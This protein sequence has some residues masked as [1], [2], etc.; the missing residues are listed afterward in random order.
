MASAYDA[1][2]DGIYY[3]L[4]TKA[5]QAEVTSGDTKYSGSV[6]IPTTV[7]YNGVAFSVTSIGTWAFSG[8]SGL[9]SV[10]IPSSVTTIEGSAFFGCSGL[11]SVTIPS[12]VTSIGIQS[13]YGCFGLTSVTIPSSVTS[14]GSG[15]FSGTAWLNNQSDGVVYAGNVAYTYKGSMPVGSAI[16]LR[17]E[18]VGIADRAFSN[19]I[20]M[21]SIDIPNSVT[22]IGS[23][24]FQDCTG[25]TSITIPNSVT[26]ISN[27]A[28]SGCTGLTSITIPNSV[29]SIGSSAFSN[30]I[31]L[32]TFT[33]PNSVTSIG[34][35]AFSGCTGLTSIT[36]PNSVTSIGGSAFDGCTGITSVAL[37]CKEIGSWFNS[38]KSIK[39]VVLGDEV[40]TIGYRAFDG[41]TGLTSITIPNS[42]TSVGDKAFSGCT[43]L[44]SITLNCIEID[45]WFR[46]AFYGCTGITSV[47]L[48]CKEIGSCF[49]SNKSIKE[50][51]LGDEVTTIGYR[52]FDGCTDLTSITI[53]NS[54]TSIG[55]SAFSSCT[56]LTSV[57]IPQSVVSVGKA[58]FKNCSN[59]TTVTLNSNIETL[60]EEAF[61]ECKMLE[62]IYIDKLDF[63]EKYS[64][65]SAPAKK[66]FINGE[67]L[68]DIVI[69][70]GV[71][72]IENYN[73]IA[74]IKTVTIPSSITSIKAGYGTK[75]EDCIYCY[76]TTPPET[77]SDSYPY[78]QNCFYAPV[79]Y[80]PY[81]TKSEYNT[82][83]HWGNT[84]LFS[85]IVEMDG[86]VEE[87]IIT[88]KEAGTLKEKLSEL[89]VT[90]I[91]HLTLRGP[92]DANDL[93]LIRARDGRLSTLDVLD[94]KDVILVPKDRVFYNSWKRAVDMTFTGYLNCI[95]IGENG[96]TEIVTGE[97]VPSQGGG[98]L[99][100]N[101]YDDLAYAFEGMPLKRV[102]WPKS[103]KKIGE[104]SF[105]NSGLEVLEMSENP[106]MIGKKAFNNCAELR[107]LPSLSGVTYL[108]SEAFGGCKQLLALDNKREINLTSLDSIPSYAFS[109]CTSIKSFVLSFNLQQIDT[110]AFKGCTSLTSVTLPESL[111][112]I[113]Y[114]AFNDTPWYNNLK[115]IDNIKYINNVAM[116]SKWESTVL[117]FREG[118]LAIADN[119]YHNDYSVSQ[120]N[121]P[122]SVN[123][124]G[125]GALSC[126][127]CATVALPS[128]LKRIGISAF[129]ASNLTSIELPE[130]LEEIGEKAFI[131]CEKLSSLKISSSVKKIGA[132]AFES[133]ALETLTV[134]ANVEEIG[135]QVFINNKSLL[136]VDYQAP[137]LSNYIFSDCTAL[138][139]ITLEGSI[140][141]I[142]EYAFANN[143]SLIKLV[144]PETLE[145]LGNSAFQN[146]TSLKSI[147]LP[148]GTT[149]IHSSFR[150]CSGIQTVIIPSSVTFIGNYAFTNCSKLTDVYCYAEQ[151]PN[152]EYVLS[153]K[154]IMTA[155]TLHVPA[156]SLEAYKATRPWSEF[157]TIVGMNDFE[158]P[159]NWVTLTKEM[160]FLWDGSG[161]DA[162]P[163]FNTPADLNLDVDVASGEVVAGFSGVEWNMYADLSKY[164]KIV[165]RG[166][167]DGNVRMLTNRLVAGGEWKEITAV[168]NKNDQYWDSEYKA[169][170]IPLDDFR[171]KSTSSNNVRVDDFVHLNAIKANWGATV[172]VQ[173]IYLVPSVL[174]GDANG[175]GEV[176]MDDAT[177]VTNIILGT[178]EATEAADVNKDGEVNMSDVMFIIN[179]IKNG[180]F[181]DE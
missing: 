73:N 17:E 85:V 47:A 110:D 109:G 26:S 37:N 22:T 40:T 172:N 171:N 181:P 105:E 86:E 134:P 43:G 114:G 135:D 179:Y 21:I 7:M 164:D 81:G 138:E 50:V 90:K 170:V 12:S 112:D 115:W 174:R 61:D 98:Y 2:V 15:A 16:H 148:E 8:C 97:G 4:I 160:F 125:S 151:V 24:A 129:A 91:R 118:T 76:A 88:L 130:S 180:K 136:R 44:T 67:Q 29:T 150:N 77:V 48:N 103:V 145:T 41:C 65:R 99:V 66:Y 39:E 133:C 70:E 104:G 92:I 34:G 52:A 74:G 54:V 5:K 140:K 146:C 84:N 25:L 120:V 31:G 147:E 122:S 75:V 139:R 116:E 154:A 126:L 152:T 142:P 55:N 165:L 78:N 9:T 153:E 157:G 121:I 119:F 100:Y 124:I 82:T 108:G 62:N 49:S 94:L 18:T 149:T 123:Y 1:Q 60:G 167:A 144:F 45:S 128:S 23:A 95:C 163:L 137:V 64:I 79:L 173:A 27:S 111:T 11:T 102:V 143:T 30:C 28:F 59:L 3:N 38:N 169:L 6:A 35:S 107:E 68:T 131:K 13:F 10:T 36:I 63:L 178:E 159:D 46:S 141:E 19:C 156:A 80:V 58:A 69:P 51:V 106:Q 132:N 175:D 32:T 83:G 71:T 158:A 101:Y 177:F 72:S 57:V 166:K 20:N 42:V 168:F 56:G 93:G 127:Q 161:A 96:R 14:I 87:I 113:P 117:N 155:A 33:I 176:D 162:T 53:S 89:D